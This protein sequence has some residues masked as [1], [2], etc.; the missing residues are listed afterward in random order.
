MEDSPATLP[1]A[2][3]P[4]PREGRHPFLPSLCLTLLARTLPLSFFCLGETR[5]SFRGH[6]GTL[7]SVL[8]PSGCPPPLDASHPGSPRAP[9]ARLPPYPLQPF[10]AVF[11]AAPRVLKSTEPQ[12]AKPGMEPASFLPP[13]AQNRPRRRSLVTERTKMHPVEVEETFPF[14]YNP[15]FG[16]FRP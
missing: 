12:P 4:S 15:T 9:F 10:F 3:S 6:S 7:E 2:N 1:A 11:R 16:P 8:V 14:F 5:V 13:R